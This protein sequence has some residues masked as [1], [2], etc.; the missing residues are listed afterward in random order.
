MF[1]KG[2]YR[3][4]RDAV[5]LVRGKSHKVRL[6]ERNIEDLRLLVKSELAI[7]LAPKNQKRLRRLAALLAKHGVRTKLE[8]R[9]TAYRL[10]LESTLTIHTAKGNPDREG[11]AGQILRVVQREQFLRQRRR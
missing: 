2:P 4:T 10:H 7:G 5:F 9:E 1:E 3:K 11:V 8:K 6:T